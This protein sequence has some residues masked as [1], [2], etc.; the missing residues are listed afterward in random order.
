MAT[1][2]TTK[3]KGKRPQTWDH[4][5]SNKK[6]PSR[7]VIIPM[8]DEVAVRWQEVKGKRDLL[9]LRLDMGIENKDV[10][11]QVVEELA[12][13]QAEVDQ[14]EAEMGDK[15]A[16]FR[17]RG[18]GRK[19]FEK[20]KENPEFEPTEEQIKT[21]VATQGPGTTLP[22]NTDT[23]PPALIAA[24]LEE[25]E[26]TLEEAQELWDSDDWTSAELLLLLDAAMEVNEKVRN[27]DWGKG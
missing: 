11:K 2:S 9:K 26:M 23:Y 14:V 12:K 24:S 4:L 10:K 8:D 3:A 18:L 17:F 15:V 13:V 20:F 27:I 7:K 16:I 19:K 21:A 1:S 5:K 22:W 25:P 6:P